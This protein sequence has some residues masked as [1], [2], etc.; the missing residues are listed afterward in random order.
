[1]RF[2]EAEI[3]DGLRGVVE[4]VALVGHGMGTVMGWRKG[5][6]LRVCLQF[7][8]PSPAGRSSQRAGTHAKC[9]RILH[10]ARG[11]AGE[12]VSNH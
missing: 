5:E 7:E 10:G 2:V 1:M 11:R 4:G 3:D 6:A 9:G 8:S 12:G